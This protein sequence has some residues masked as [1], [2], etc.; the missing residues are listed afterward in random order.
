MISSVIGDKAKSRITPV[1]KQTNM[2]KEIGVSARPYPGNILL[3]NIITSHV[4]KGNGDYKEQNPPGTF[5]FVVQQ[6]KCPKEY[7]KGRPV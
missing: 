4:G 7:I 3:K 1:D 5:T 2:G 6:D